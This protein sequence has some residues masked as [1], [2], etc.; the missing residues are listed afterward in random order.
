MVG[1]HF[2]NK[3]TIST[4]HQYR[5]DSFR[6]TILS[7][8]YCL[9]VCYHTQW[10]NIWQYLTYSTILHTIYCLQYCC[11]YIMVPY[12]S[13]LI[14]GNLTYHTILCMYVHMYFCLHL[15]RNSL[16]TDTDRQRRNSLHTDT[17]RQQTT[18]DSL[19]ISSIGH[20]L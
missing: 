10:R 12:S 11:L 19:I 13:G 16:H 2:C 14:I 17:D 8:I 4:N 18:D 20:G 6:P 15:G 5:I 7:T 9:L 3:S 1:Y